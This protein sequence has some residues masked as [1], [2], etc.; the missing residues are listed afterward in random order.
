MKA[1]QK[2]SCRHA[3]PSTIFSEIPPP[4]RCYEKCLKTLIYFHVLVS[5]STVM[6]L[7]GNADMAKRFLMR[8]QEVA[9]EVLGS[10]HHYV[11]A[12]IGQVCNFTFN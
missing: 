5:F 6:R 2:G 3:S 4:Q 10:N 7:Q 12:I 11:A 1:I 8:S 9:T